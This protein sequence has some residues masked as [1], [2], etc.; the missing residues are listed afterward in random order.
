MTASL[1]C[2]S[3]RAAGKFRCHFQ[4]TI[5]ASHRHHYRRTVNRAI[6]IH[7]F[8]SDHSPRGIELDAKRH[9]SRLRR[10]AQ[11]LKNGYGSFDRRP[12]N[13]PCLKLASNLHAVHRV[14]WIVI[15]SREIL[16]PEVDGLAA[17]PDMNTPTRMPTMKSTHDFTKVSESSS[18]Q[19]RSSSPERPQQRRM[20]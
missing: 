2:Y 11:C 20:A 4:T 3:I 12:R 7:R 13:A 10:P 17:P 1:H 6:P 15:R 9:Y 16:Q 14:A 5:H 19:S 8:N 18:E